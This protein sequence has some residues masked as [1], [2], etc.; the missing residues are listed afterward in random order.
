MADRVGVIS[1]GEL[2]AIDEKTSLMA[3]M[4]KK[5]LDI[6]LVEPLDAVPPVLAEWNV[7]LESDGHTLC[8]EFDSHAERTG[9]A[10]LMRALGDA[11]IAYK[12]LSTHQSSL[13]DIFVELVRSDRKP[14]P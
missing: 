2:I 7:R 4:G 3:K 14:K 10:S 8:Y 11:G 1:R 6:M 13:E 12:D 5:T 9:I